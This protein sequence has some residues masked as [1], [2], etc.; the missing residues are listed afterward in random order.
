MNVLFLMISFPDIN[1]DSNLYSDLAEEFR[2]NGHQVYLATLLEKK[3]NLNTYLENVKNLSIL[4]VRAGNW[5]N[6]NSLLVKG[7]TTLTIAN[8]FKKDI[9]KYFNKIKFDLV[10]YPTPP[11]TF[12]PVVKYLKQRDKGAS[13]LILRDI[14][15][16]NVRDLG[17]LNNSFLYNYFRLKEKKLY[18]ISDYIGCMSKGNIQYVLDHNDIDENK[19]EVLY[20]WGKVFYNSEVIAVDYKKKYGLENKFVAVFGGNI[21]LPQELEFLL[22]LAKEYKYRSDVVFFIIGKGAQK[23]KIVNLIDYHKLSNVIIK[24]YIP[25]DEYRNLLKQCDIGLINLNRTFTIPNMPC[26]VVDYFNASIPILAS[27]DKNT[28]LKQF[29]QG[30]NAGLWSETG[31]LEAYKSNFEKLLNDKKLRKEL[32][33][34]GRKFLEENLSVERAYQII[35]KH[36][37]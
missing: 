25:R 16:Q 5:F 31:D 29:L 12:A 7:I 30:A 11:I 18:N 4:R 33:E 13:Y 26:K 9:K 8:Y 27:T 32:G 37:E 10:I 35:N 2:N 14:F 17:L 22:E 15:P 1:K 34:N 24:D 6:T 19:L 23:E 3:Y 28:D 36:F 20:N 21:G